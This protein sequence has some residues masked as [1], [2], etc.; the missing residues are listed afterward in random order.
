MLEALP[1]TKEILK[2]VKGMEMDAVAITDNGTM[3]GAIE[4]YQKAM[5][6]G[7]KPIIGIDFYLASEDRKLKRAH[8]DTKPLRLVCLAETNE[9]YLNLIK[10]STIGFLEGFYYK[11]RID[12]NV[13]QKHTK[14][15]IALSGG[16]YGEIDALLKLD[17][18]DEAG[19][20]ISWYVEVFGEGNFYLELV[21]SPEIAE[22]EATNAKLI[23]L[24]REMH[25]P[26]VAT[27]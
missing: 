10:L 25:V 26:V 17:R 3:Y 6:A 4:F 19:A 22:Q 1:K 15:L 9:G 14:G 24:S 7:V 5:D 13:L 23:K 8:I 12:K 11:P 20:A 27:K 21:D 16:V 2:H 18:L